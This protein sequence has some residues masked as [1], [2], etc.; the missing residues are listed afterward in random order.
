MLNRLIDR[1]SDYLVRNKGMPVLLGVVL[2]ILNYAVQFFTH[3]PVL[4]FLA[5]TNLFL[6]L[7]I[8]IGL[9]GILLG[10]AL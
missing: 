9:V 7:G 5:G 10:D 6:H 1:T 8:I 4:G 2:V 3:V